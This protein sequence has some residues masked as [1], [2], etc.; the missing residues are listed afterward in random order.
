[1]TDRNEALRLAEPPNIDN[2]KKIAASDSTTAIRNALLA[3]IK[4][5]QHL[6]QSLKFEQAASFRDQVAEL[7]AERDQL[8][9]EV[10]RLRVDAE[11]IDYLE[12]EINELRTR[13]TGEDDYE[14][15]VRSNHMDQPYERD[16]GRGKTIRAA[17]DHAR[18]TH[19]ETE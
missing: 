9:A 18:T 4:W 6:E 17:I 5:V 7:E 10:E 11:R 13:E 16:V 8:R 14:W 15:V 19:K 2:L 1:M 3:A 12:Y